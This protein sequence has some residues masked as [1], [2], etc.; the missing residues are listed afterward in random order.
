MK[1]KPKFMN[2]LKPL[3]T[4]QKGG[5]IFQMILTFYRRRIIM[6]GTVSMIFNQIK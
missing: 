2:K 1:K 6:R 3:F 5:I 4:I